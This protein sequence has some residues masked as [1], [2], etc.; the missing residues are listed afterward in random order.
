MRRLALTSAVALCAFLLLVPP[1]SAEWVWPVRGE[2]ITS[3]R[4]GTDPYAPGQHRGIDVAAATGA[5]VVAAASGEVRFAGT[6]GS[7]GLTVSVRTADGRYDTSYLH[8]SS[9]SVREGDRVSAGQALG[10]VGTT[11]TRSATESHLHL[12]VREAG[13][14]HAYHDPLDLLPRPTAP[15]PPEGAPAPEPAPVPISPAPAPTPISAPEPRRI[16]VRAPAPRRVPVGAPRTVPAIDLHRVPAGEPH[17]VPAGEPQPIPAGESQRVPAGDRHR[18]PAG[19]PHRAAPAQAGPAQMPRS[20]GPDIGLL[21]ACLGGLA[22]AAFLGLAARRARP[23]PRRL[24]SIDC[25]CRT[26]SPRPS[27][28]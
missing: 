16:P 26:T 1:A 11:G 15:R 27:T 14:R 18:V 23:S 20:S 21:A 24:G 2:V 5:T 7:S 6:A 19:E 25:P 28:T 12:G 13:S 8:L 17:R 4:Y 10:A 22:A 3:Y 9:T